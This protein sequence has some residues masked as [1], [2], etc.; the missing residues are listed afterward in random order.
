MKA[1]YQGKTYDV[2]NRL[3]K[4]GIWWSLDGNRSLIPMELQERVKKKLQYGAS[5]MR[6]APQYEWSR[7]PEPM[8]R[9]CGKC[10]DYHYRIVADKNVMVQ[11]KNCGHEWRLHCPYCSQ[12]VTKIERWENSTNH[13]QISASCCGVRNGRDWNVST[14]NRSNLRYLALLYFGSECSQCGSTA[15]LEAD[16]IIAIKNGGKDI[17]TNMQ[18]LCRDCHDSKTRSDCGGW[19]PTRA[20]P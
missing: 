14:K 6:F 15:H 2:D 16:H 10:G 19:A 17:L 5:E 13:P 18:V 11:C 3:S 12:P 20:A 7:A 1:T 4:E 9:T 8:G